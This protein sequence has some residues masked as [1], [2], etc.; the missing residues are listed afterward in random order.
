VSVLTG[1]TQIVLPRG[2]GNW[3]WRL[4]GYRRGD[5]AKQGPHAN[6]STERRFR[7][8]A[9]EDKQGLNSGNEQPEV[10]RHVIFTWGND[11]RFDA[12]KVLRSSTRP[13]VNDSAS[14][15]VSGES[16]NLYN[17]AWRRRKFTLN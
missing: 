13:H 16:K 4:R 15:Q 9:T 17:A 2:D 8:L 10:C 7:E 6:E 3:R 5:R 12:E 1:V 11:K 14:P